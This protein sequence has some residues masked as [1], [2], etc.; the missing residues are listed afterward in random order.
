[1]KLKLILAVTLAIAFVTNVTAQNF[2]PEFSISKK[3]RKATEPLGPTDYVR[4]E[5]AGQNKYTTMAALKKGIPFDITV[6]NVNLAAVATTNLLT[7]PAGVKFIAIAVKVECTTAGATTAPTLSVGSTGTSATSIVASGA[8]NATPL[9]G[10][11][12][13]LTLQGTSNAFAAADVITLPVTVA[14]TGGTSV[15]TV[16]LVG[17][18][19]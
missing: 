15:A 1:M 13:T 8:L 18:Y 9:V 19:Y 10:Q 14:A 2:A 11:V 3:L 16:H 6:P 4:I 5:S 7:I 12:Q 17:F